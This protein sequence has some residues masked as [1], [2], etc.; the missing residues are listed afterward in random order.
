MPRPDQGTFLHCKL[1]GCRLRREPRTCSPTHNLNHMWA[2]SMICRATRF[3]MTDDNSKYWMQGFGGFSCHISATCFDHCHLCVTVFKAHW[4]TGLILCPILPPFLKLRVNLCQILYKPGIVKF[5]QHLL[6]WMK[7]AEINL[8][9]LWEAGRLLGG[10]HQHCDLTM[11]VC[12]LLVKGRRWTSSWLPLCWLISGVTGSPE[13][14]LLVIAFQGVARMWS[15]AA[16]IRCAHLKML[17]F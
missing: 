7:A 15:A 12:R 6:C 16:L 4:T 13:H 9:L 3:P 11:C 8:F 10:P 2:F 17:I 1:M 5:T 14:N